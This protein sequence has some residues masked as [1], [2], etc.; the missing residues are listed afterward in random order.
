MIPRPL[1]IA[2]ACSFPLC[3]S[4]A[5]AQNVSGVFGP[6]V[7]G[8]ESNIEYR[9]GYAPERGRSLHR[10]EYEQAESERLMWRG[11]VILTDSEGDTNELDSFTGQAWYE[12]R[13]SEKRW[14][15]G[16]RGDVTLRPGGPATLGLL[17]TNEYAATDRL[18]FRG[19]ILGRSDIGEEGR[20]GL[21]LE[22]RYRAAWRRDDG[23]TVGIEVF[24]PLGSADSLSL[25]GPEQ[26]GPFASGPIGE[27]WK[28]TA[29]LLVGAKSEASDVDLRFRLTRD[30]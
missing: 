18:S 23:I 29:G 17:W 6:V 11:I 12:L 22:G 24:D 14:R 25:E 16:F 19:L 8:D 10:F 1:I 5:L 13:G 7:R 30:F 20:D 2:F 15:T 3:T 9:F 26:A 28:V 4:G 21:I 27:H